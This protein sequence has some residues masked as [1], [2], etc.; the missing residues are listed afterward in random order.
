[1][2][3]IRS[4][5]AAGLVAVLAATLAAQTAPAH[6]A[7]VVYE[8]ELA[9]IINGAAESTH[10]GFTGTGYVNSA[11]AV[12]AAVEFAVNSGG[13]TETLVFR[14][15][16]GATADRPATIT[17]DG[18]TRAT[19]PFPP[20]GSWSTWGTQTVTASLA[21]GGNAVRATATT[22]GGLANLDSLTVGTAPPGHPEVHPALAP[23]LAAFYDFAHPSATNAA[24]EVD[25]GLSGTNLRLI[26]GGAAMRVRDGAYPA[27][28]TSIQVQQIRPTVASNDDWKAGIYSSSGVPTL[29]AFNR[30]SGTTI[31]GWFKLTGQ[32]PTPNSN[33]S[34]PND[35]YGAVGLAGILTGNSDGHAVRALLEVFTVN[36]GLRLV[37]LG[38][39]V[40]GG[41]SQI[42]AATEDWRTLLPAN[43]WVFLAATFDFDRGTMALYKNGRPIPG[44][45][46]VSGDPWGINGP[47]EPDFTSATNPRGIKIGGSFPQN[48]RENNACNCR[49]DSLMF[50][51]RALSAG[52]VAMQ[53][54][55]V[56]GQR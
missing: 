46:T 4:T 13:G 28:T 48:T 18:V 52:E 54:S 39:R 51:N 53:Y 36:G 10:P 37:A 15:A 45:N 25:Q 16:N 43:T 31:M 33:S 34:D 9:T 24:I 14:Y 47:P 7:P 17:V 27:S 5:A 23:S 19:L 20:T 30:V 29:S 3:P 1:M 11:N 2:T 56:T 6:A 49:M 12:D 26:N 32:N 50:L 21:A 22:S 40:D 8:A 35:R 44:A 55:H 38:R 41:S 42:F